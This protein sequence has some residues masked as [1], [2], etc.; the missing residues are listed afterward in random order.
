MATLQVKGIDDRLYAALKAKAAAEKRSISQQVVHMI[1]E[2]LRRP[3]RDIG[4][5]L[6]RLLEMAGTWKDDRT[7]AQVAADIRKGRRTS[8]RFR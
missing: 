4:G 3:R 1:C 8:R 7:P 2:G 5:G 6:A